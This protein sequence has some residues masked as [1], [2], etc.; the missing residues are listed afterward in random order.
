MQAEATLQA[1]REARATESCRS[2]NVM[3]AQ[4]AAAKR[5]QVARADADRAR[6][7]LDR[8][9]D[10]LNAT[11]RGLPGEPASACVERTATVSQLLSACA[12]EAQELA[13]AADGHANDARTLIE[14]GRSNEGALCATLSCFVSSSR[15]STDARVEF[16]PL[17]ERGRFVGLM[18]AAP[19]AG[20]IAVRFDP[21][22]LCRE[23]V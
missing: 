19:Q 21:D 4:N 15:S 5:S 3:E 10:T 13:R 16:A 7:E 22:D 18:I 9:R 14:A 2:L 23:M 12:A 1:S 8:L 6:S 17:C 20:A 11:S